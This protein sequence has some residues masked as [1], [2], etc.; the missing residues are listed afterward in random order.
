[1]ATLQATD[2]R[3][4]IMKKLSDNDRTLGWLSEKTGYKYSTLYSIFVQKTIKLSAERKLRISQV[5][6]AYS[7]SV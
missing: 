6:E 5:C 3:D 1:M 2:E 4:F 7:I